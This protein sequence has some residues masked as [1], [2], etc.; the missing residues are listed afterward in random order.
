VRNTGYTLPAEFWGCFFGDRTAEID[1][2]AK[3]ASRY[4]RRILAP[5]AATGEVAHALSR[6]GFTVVAVDLSEEMVN[7]GR[8]RHPQSNRLRWVRA[9]VTRLALKEP[10]FDFA[11]LGNGDFHH[12]LDRDA[13][14]AVLTRLGAHVRPGGAIGLE[15]FLPRPVSWASPRRRFPPLRPLE[16]ARVRVWKEGS[17]NFDVET[18][19]L[20]IL[21]TL[22]VARDGREERIPHHLTLQLYDRVEIR[23][24]LACAGLQTLSEF[25]SYGLDPWTPDADAWILVAERAEDGAE[26]CPSALSSQE[27]SFTRSGER[28]QPAVSTHARRAT[29]RPVRQSRTI[30]PMCKGSARDW[31]QRPYQC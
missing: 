31:R 24:V 15:L 26:V 2:W 20:E 25:G 23:G 21:Q 6:R 30:R 11:F 16:D 27:G 14:T 3:L 7:E 12:F 22:V 1:G 29:V 4:G 19:R 10:A 13:Q 5:M 8:R 9:D 28:R 18:G 17:T